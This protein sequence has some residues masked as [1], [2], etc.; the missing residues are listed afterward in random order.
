MAHSHASHDVT[1]FRGFRGEPF[2]TDG[3]SAPSGPIM[4]RA[5]ERTLCPELPQDHTPS[6][7]KAT[8][9]IERGLIESV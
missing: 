1:P 4:S 7:E 8:A 5:G 6:K 9:K 2:S 3:I